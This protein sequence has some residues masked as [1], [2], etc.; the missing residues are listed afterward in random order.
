[1]NVV[2]RRGRTL[3]L[4]GGSV[5]RV[6]LHATPNGE[7]EAWPKSESG[8]KAKAHRVRIRIFCKAQGGQQNN[9]EQGA[10]TDGQRDEPYPAQARK[11]EFRRM[12]WTEFS[13]V[14]R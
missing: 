1:M 7:A 9:N 3:L 10:S 12:R 13:H 6:R 14:W 4:S 11:V 8:Q 5:A 2:L